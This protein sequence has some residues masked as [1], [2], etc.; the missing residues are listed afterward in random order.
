METIAVYWEAPIRIYG[1]TEKRSLT[2]LRLEF[3]AT[4]LEYWAE[5]VSEIEAHGDFELLFLQSTDAV[6]RLFLLPSGKDTADLESELRRRLAV[7]GGAAMSRVAPVAVLYLF[8]PH[9]QDR[10]GIAE[11]ALSPLRQENISVHAMG[12]AG[13]S[14][15]LVVDDTSVE[16]A[17]AAL[18]KTFVL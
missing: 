5:V 9:F 11:A 12:C 18:S 7:E 14:I 4:R 16:K 17:R 15:Y 1:L 6:C 3:P 8:G 13:T 10:F 2:L